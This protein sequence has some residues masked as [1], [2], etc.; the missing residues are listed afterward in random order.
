[1]KEQKAGTKRVLVAMSGGVDSSVAAALLK[2]QGWDVIGVHFNLWNP[3]SEGFRPK[4]GGSCCK[5]NRQ[6]NAKNVCETLEIPLYTVDLSEEYRATVMDYVINER[7]QARTPNPCALCHGVLKFSALIEKANQLR[8]DWVATGHYAKV[9]RNPDGTE[10]NLYKA[11]DDA[12][13]QSYFLFELNQKDLARTL[14]PI[15]ELKQ[16]NVRKMAQTFQLP[17]EVESESTQLCFG[18]ISSKTGPDW[19]DFV[20]KSSPDRYRV[21]GPI[22]LQDG[23]SISRHQGLFQYYIGQPKAP[24]IADSKFQDL[25]VLGFDMK[26]NALIVGEEK[27]LLRTG[28]LATNCNWIGLQDFSRG[29]QAKAKIHY[30]VPEASCRVT[31]LNN[32][33]VIVDFDE[34]Q[35]AITPGL[36]IVFYQDDLVLGGGWIEALTEPINTRM[37]IRH[38][39]FK[40]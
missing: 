33:S 1:V 12:L 32:Q 27:E 5:P 28:L 6:E 24:G 25:F 26:I 16:A 9:V 10:T 30:N 21:T 22:V 36:P 7:L 37:K 17:T 3:A 4:S 40:L 23:A 13:D 29:V 19:I 15:G 18:G 20:Q 8:C 31:L 34:P 2:T 11:T 38:Q 35:R 39:G 14:M